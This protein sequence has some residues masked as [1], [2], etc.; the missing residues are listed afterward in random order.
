MQTST[1]MLLTGLLRTN[2]SYASRSSLGFKSDSV[3]VLQRHQ[4]AMSW[5]D[6]NPLQVKRLFAEVGMLCSTFIIDHFELFLLRNCLLLHY[7]QCAIIFSFVVSFASLSIFSIR[8]IPW[9]AQN[10]EAFLERENSDEVMQ[11]KKILDM[12]LPGI[13]NS[14]ELLINKVGMIYVSC[15]LCSMGMR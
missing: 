11:L 1:Q 4:D 6:N 12:H 13:Q 14:G 3:E 2:R 8:S 7:F 15:N 5:Y 9:Q 10:T